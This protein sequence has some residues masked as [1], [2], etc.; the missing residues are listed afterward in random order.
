M[1]STLLI[2]FGGTGDL[3]TRKLLP[4]IARMASRRDTGGCLPVLAV[5]RDP[6]HTDESYRRLARQ[7]LEA[8]GV[9]PEEATGFC[10]DWVYYQSIGDGSPGRYRDLAARVEAIGRDRNLQGDRAFYLALPPSAYPPTIEGLAESGLLANASGWVR[11][12]IEKP[13]GHDLASAQALNELL[14][15]HVD[16]SQIYRIDHYLG[17]E[18]VQNLLIFRFANA[19]FESLWNRDRIDHVQITVAEALGLVDRA[20]YYDRTGALRDMIQNHVTQL[21]SLVAMEVPASFD[22]ASVRYEKAKVLQSVQP[23][24]DDEIVFGQYGAGRVGDRDAIGYLA[25]PGVATGS[26]T[27]TYVAMT[28]FVDNWRW[29]G[30]PFY[31]RTGKR[32]AES[33]TEIAVTFRRAPVCLFQSLGNCLITSNVLVLTLQPHEGFSLFIDVKRPGDPLDLA[34]VPLS[35]KYQDAFGRLADAYETLM[36]EVIKGDQTHFVRGDFTEMAWSLYDSVLARRPEAHL[37]PAGTWGPEAADRLLARGG[38][39]WRN[40]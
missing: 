31:V 7:A 33:R 4:A 9:T 24:L 18:T 12:V 26:T 5:A 40:A 6:K 11:L 8:A 38:H 22:E 15:R 32:L 3:A 25:E 13:F 39:R 14:H 1:S 37:Y 16:E 10:D 34:P 35:F 19:I 21:L 36:L 17:K 30:V 20:D 29:Q 28:L 23:P 2:V 27:E